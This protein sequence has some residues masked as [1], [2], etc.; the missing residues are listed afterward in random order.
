[1]NTDAKKNLAS[2]INW[3]EVDYDDEYGYRDNSEGGLMVYAVWP[4]YAQEAE[5]CL[6]EAFL[7]FGEVFVG[8]DGPLEA[9]I[10]RDE[11]AMS[12]EANNRADYTEEP[13]Y[14]QLFSSVVLIGSTG[15]SLHKENSFVAGNQYFSA[16][17]DDLSESGE[18]LISS[19]EALYGSKATLVTFLDT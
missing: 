17:R 1:M 4:Y 18:A 13:N 16:S 10:K 3:P 12:Q 5:S 11:I 14:K 2:T 19:L 7:D 6:N 9:Q 8:A 15:Q